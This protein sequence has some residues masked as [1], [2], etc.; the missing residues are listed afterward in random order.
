MDLERELKYAEDS[1]KEKLPKFIEMTF[2]KQ[3]HLNAIALSGKMI[4]LSDNLT[5][6]PFPDN[7]IE[8]EAF[9]IGFSS[10]EIQVT[11]PS[12]DELS[13]IGLEFIEKAFQQLTNGNMSVIR[14]SPKSLV[15]IANGT[16]IERIYAL[17]QK[18]Y[19]VK[20]TKS[21]CGLKSPI[22]TLTLYL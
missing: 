20:M 8:N 18:A 15:F 19:S 7:T 14:H 10:V 4:A 11:V 5:P 9:R 17:C 21:I 12:Q 3:A 13:W 16:D 6:N 2:I 22:A 1:L